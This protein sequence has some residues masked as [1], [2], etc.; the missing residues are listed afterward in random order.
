[1]EIRQLRTLLA[2]VN[3]GSFAS[4]AKAIGLTQSAVSQ[5]V[6]ALETELQIELFDRVAR[7]MSLTL[8][9]RTLL[10]QAQRIV[11][12]LDETTVKLKSEP[13][14]GVLN[15][16]VLRGS[17]MGTLPAA[18]AMLRRRYPGLKVLLSTGD[19]VDLVAN[20]KAKRMDAALVPEVANLDAQLNWL[21]YFVE[22]FMVIAPPGTPGAS[23]RELLEARP[24]IQ[25]SRTVRSGRMIADEIERRGIRVA[26]EMEIDSFPAIVMMVEEGLG[27]AVAPSQSIGSSQASSLRV[28]PFGAPAL[29]RTIGIVARR[30]NPKAALVAALHD[31]LG[32][33]GRA[34]AA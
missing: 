33:A 13:L 15:L 3:A 16:G 23:D 19:L 10:E 4:A 34:V 17:M 11:A 30:A 6:R 7:P 14:T 5:Q 32:G 21:P 22:P 24:F 18:L 26:T 29:T 20:V 9:G 27:V 31:A 25:F 28:L 8:E 2:I 1:M 12:L